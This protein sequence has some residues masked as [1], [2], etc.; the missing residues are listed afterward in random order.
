MLDTITH[1]GNA[2][3]TTWDAT[4]HPPGWVTVKMTMTSVGDDVEN[5]SPY[6]LLVGTLD[7]T[8]AVENGQFLK[9]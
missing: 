9:T 3:K 7:G 5:H 4:A 6:T 1:Q 2:T 8:A